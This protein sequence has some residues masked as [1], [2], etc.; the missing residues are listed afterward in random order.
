MRIDQLNPM[1]SARL[2]VIDAEATPRAAALSFSKP[3]IGLIIVCDASGEAAGVLSKSFTVTI[4]GD[5][6]IEPNETLI[7][8]MTN[9]VGASKF[10]GAGVGTIT[11]DD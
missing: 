9:T 6:T 1:T 2:M 5:V 11:N 4:N 7:V 10:D 8:N 3:G